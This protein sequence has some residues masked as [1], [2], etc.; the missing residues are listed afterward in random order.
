M[1]SNKGHMK[2]PNNVTTHTPPKRIKA[3]DIIVGRRV[4]EMRLLLDMSQTELGNLISLT[5]QQIQKY[6]HSQNRISAVIRYFAHRTSY[7]QITGAIAYANQIKH[8]SGI[9]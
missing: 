5:F 6:G 9:Y 8:K 1:V 7:Q 2:M 4:R 3:M